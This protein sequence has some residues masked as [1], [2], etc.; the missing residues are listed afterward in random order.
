[1]SPS[2][3]ISSV[4]S[5][6]YQGTPTGRLDSSSKTRSKRPRSHPTSEGHRRQA[7]EPTASSSDTSPTTPREHLDAKHRPP[8][9]PFHH[10]AVTRSDSS[11]A[12]KVEDLRGQ[13]A[14]ET[15]WLPS[16][17]VLTGLEHCSVPCHRALLYTLLENRVTFGENLD[18]AEPSYRELPQDFILVYVCLFDPRERP[19]IHKSLVRR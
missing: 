11:G 5:S 1:M 4:F 9:S 12:V 14:S 18:G 10:A 2:S 7:S 3:F 19:P 17:L 15:S 16:A 6:P 13:Q 8:L